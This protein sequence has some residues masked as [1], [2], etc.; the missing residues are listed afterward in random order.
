MDK[1]YEHTKTEGKWYKF[2]ETEGYF[3]P[4]PDPNKQPFTI[5]MPPPNA[6]GE[7]HIG[8][9]LFVTI[10]D[11]LTRY[12]R[13]KGDS[14]LWLPGADHAGI[15]T[16]VVYE[17]ELEKE[18]KTRFDLGREEF[19]RQT[20]EFSMKNKVLMEN[21]LRRL[22]ASCDWSREKFTLDPE[23]SKTVLHTFVRLYSEGLI[24]RGERVINWCPR[25][26]TTL[27]DLEV[28]Y[29]EKNPQ[30]YYFKYPIKDSEEFIT[31]ATVRP[32]TMLGDT[33]VAV[34]PKDKRY[35]NLVGKTV[36]LPLVKR[37]IPIVSDDFVN[38]KF[39]SGAVKVTPA[40]DP[41][42]FEIS[43][44]HNLPIIQV[45]GFDDLMTKQAGNYVGL[46]KEAARK[47]VLADLEKLGLIAK[48]EEYHHSVG[49]CERC[50]TIVEPLVSKQWFVKIAPLAEKAI[51]AVKKGEIKILPKRFEK[52]YFNWMENIHD[53]NIS[54][55]LWWGHQIPV[56]YCDMCNETVVSVEK[57]KVCP[58]CESHSLTQDSDTLDTWFSSG[59]WPFTA[60]GYPNS[61]DY[62]YFYPT[63][64]METGYDILF[65]WVARMIMLGI[66]V[67]G[68]VPFE[69]VYLHG[70][71][72][73]EKGQKMS[74]SKGNVI[75]PLEVAD[76]YGADAVRASLIFGTSPGADINLGESKIKGM[77]NFTN[78][79]WN[80]ARFV[81]DMKPEKVTPEDQ[82]ELTKEDKWILEELNKTSKKTTQALENYRFSDGLQELYD[83]IWHKFADKFVEYSKSRR[84]E[85]QA[86]L[87]K[88]LKTSMELLHPYMPYITEEIWQKLDKA[89]SLSE[90]VKNK[91]Q[92]TS[93]IM[94]SPWPKI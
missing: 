72:R 14:T 91:N 9:A 38:P 49:T 23:I 87:E 90:R 89:H 15:L 67:T 27:S 47:Q 73:D 17:R 2:W 18:G 26:S 93:S 77:R 12:H 62:Q 85:T 5:I 36:L 71:V 65:F 25:C 79:I 3:T 52:I 56:Y 1:V 68:K 31:V 43:Q 24:Y 92:D 50:G 88:V 94:I 55:Q 11:I 60:L 6:N 22:G 37:E 82:V 80:I 66:Y 35:K 54:R 81:I 83:F 42:D 29:K 59:Q 4:T 33:A 64:V 16:Q 41:N 76:K 19:Y 78:K 10:E 8:H 61:K 75:N 21:Q 39:G 51:Q 20:Y 13:M 84:G 48:K 70:L 86:I 34:N 40:H 32:E 7:L 44:R 30:L 63:T 58:K 69:T 57:P 46:R 28:D 53:W 74:K 45:I